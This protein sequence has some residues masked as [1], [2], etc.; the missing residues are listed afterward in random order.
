VLHRFGVEVVNYED[1]RDARRALVST[2]NLKLAYLGSIY[3]DY[4]AWKEGDSDDE[5]GLV[6]TTNLKKKKRYNVHDCVVT[7]R[8]WKGIT[9][10]PEWGT[11]RVQR[12]YEHQRKLAV[13]GAAMHR[14]GIRVDA[15]RRKE[16]ADELEA[17]YNQ[18]EADFLKK[19]GIPGF[20]CN[21]NY[22]RALIFEKHATGKYAAFGRFN[23]PD[24]IDPAF[25]K[26]REMT[27]IKVDTAALTLLLIDPTV[28]QELKD[29]IQAYWDAEEVWKLRS[30]FVVSKRI[31]QAIGP[32]GRLRAGWN[33]C[34]TDTGRF[35]CSEPNLMNIPASE[36]T[37]WAN[38]RSMYV[39]A[40]GFTFIGADYSQLELR[41]MA[42]VAKDDALSQALATADVYTTEAIDYFQ[43][44][45][46][47]TKETIKPE[48]RKA[49]KI[50]RLARQ[51]GAGEKKGFQ[52]AVQV[53]RNMTF[54]MFRPLL[55]AFDRRNWRTVAYWDEEMERVLKTGYSETRIMRRRR[56]YP[57][58]PER[59]E[60]ANYPI[61]GTAADIKNIALIEVYE[62]FQR[63][64]M[65]SR[66]VVDLHDAIYVEAHKKEKSAVYDIMRAA[67]EKTHHIDGD[68]YVFPAKFKESDCWGDLA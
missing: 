27:R 4:H 43:L 36:D 52:I 39:A 65:K 62:E 64:G 8:V 66:I 58:E 3:T 48:A 22:M 45:P 46:D 44:P 38:V 14:V 21:P 68:D 25:Y 47:T 49:A 55:K 42:A 32:D 16:L 30:T 13:I 59:S 24:P 61:Q 9:S 23:L 19:V 35:A 33:S 57:R 15:K 54:Q 34:G 12:L 60:V 2:S 6:F 51:Y 41:V 50:I 5:K 63:R 17:L 7:A 28:P 53:N 37:P 40:P 20:Q 26:D 31:D 67:M 29:I 1:T 18:R 11:P 10:E 56:E